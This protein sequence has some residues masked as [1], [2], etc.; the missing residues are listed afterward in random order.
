V[1]FYFAVLATAD[2]YKTLKVWICDV[3]LDFGI[4]MALLIATNSIWHWREPAF[5]NKFL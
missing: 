3:Y 2:S 5:F 4:S 1:K